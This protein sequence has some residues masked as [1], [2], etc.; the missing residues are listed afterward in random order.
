MKRKNF[1][2]V[3]SFCVVALGAF[4]LTGCLG[5]KAAAPVAGTSAEP[6]KVLYEKA[7]EDMKHGRY[8]T[9]RLALQTVINTYPDSEYLAKAKLAIGDSYFKE[10]GT[11]G[12]KQSIVEYKDFIT[13]FPF[14][15]ESAYAQ[16]QIATAHLRQ[17]EKPDR[18]HAE[19]VQAE[20]EYQTFLEKYPNSPLRPQAEQHLRDVQEV[21]AEGNFRVADFYY[22]RAAYRAA[23]ARL[24]E[25]TTRY[26]LYS[27]ADQAN[28]MLGQIYE[29]TEHNDIAAKYYA[30][31]VKDYPISSLAGDAKN[32][33]VKFGV[34]VPP[35]DPTAVAR[36]QQE[37]N[38]PRPG[39]IKRSMGVLKNSP[40]YSAAARSGDP[41]MTPASESG[42]E[43][44]GFS[45]QP[46]VPAVA[47]GSSVGSSATVETITPGSANA[48]PPPAPTPA[49][50]TPASADSSTGTS[51]TDSTATTPT[52]TTAPPANSSQ[53][54]T[55]KK[56]GGLRKLIPF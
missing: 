8:A 36:M 9:G 21:L 44:I 33:L 1:K 34:P 25:L 39:L 10:G 16:M 41:T 54:S 50:S 26:P 3:Q 19:A 30:R 15:E 42:D 38:A 29:K 20:A 5:K 2:Q 6:D 11:A 23:G 45:L 17:M 53:E 51:K 56:K 43:T 46:N 13:F 48:L 35:A 18:D 7:T 31:I 4:L 27:Q 47:T 52:T 55:S 32:K 14:L 40:D 12:L 24:M 28:W 22:L 49:D 37:Q